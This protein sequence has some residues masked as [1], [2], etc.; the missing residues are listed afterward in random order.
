MSD[1]PENTDIS[2]LQE[3]LDSQR[4]AAN[5]SKQA[6]HEFKLALTKAREDLSKAREEKHEAVAKL[7]D[8]PIR[9]VASPAKMK[10]RHYGMLL[11]FVVMVLGPI[12][13][14]SYYLYDRA[15]DQY[16]ST[17]G[18]TVRTEDV[19][20][21][22]DLLSGFGGALTGG[23]SSSRDTDVLYEFMRSQDLVRRVDQELDL[24]SQYSRYRD[25]DPLFGFNPTGTI[26]DL[27]DFWQRMV[28]VSYDAGSGLMELR[29]LAF[30]PDE[31]QAIAQTIF[32]QSSVMINALSDIARKDATRYAREDLD[33]AGDHLKTAREALTAFRLANQIVDVEA[34][35]QGQ[36][37]LLNT[38][39][40]Q[41]AEALIELDLLS[42]SV[43]DD[44]PRLAQAQ[45]R[46]AVINARVED[47]R[48]KFGSG[49][50]GPGGADYATVVAE[51]E[52]LTVDRE[53]AELAYAAARSNFDSAN[54]EATRQSRYLAAYIAPTRA[55][56]AEFPQ[57]GLL[58]GT[59]ALFSLLFWVVASL[60]YYSLRER[61]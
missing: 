19:S 56:R 54:A 8:A 10:K 47:E 35:I 42:E 2:A 30:D 9:P 3:E 51:F 15:V 53:F 58:L 41:L 33:T 48:R 52:R 1:T 13:I 49:G 29:V 37:G 21:A 27:T 24:R 5:L 25:V 7:H 17:V 6:A 44:D 36:M 16:A 28:R 14:A 38:L 22:A 43:K 50:T 31:A 32:T 40:A 46:L 23:S 57:R 4:K 55:E 11:S 26:E 12:A 61:R 59:V 34:D 60:I 39:Q 45:R 20:S 18:F